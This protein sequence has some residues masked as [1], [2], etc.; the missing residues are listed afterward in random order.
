M[1][2]PPST[3]YVISR[4]HSN[5]PSL[6]LSQKVRK[7]WTDSY[8][9]RQMLMFYPPPFPHPL[10]F[11]CCDHEQ[12][13]VNQVTRC[14]IIYKFDHITPVLQE[15]RWL[16]VRYYLMYTV[17]VLTFKWVK[18]IVSDCISDYF[19]AK[20]WTFCRRENESRRGLTTKHL[21][22]VLFTPLH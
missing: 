1:A 15:L 22:F 8:W 2:W 13:L 21:P 7:G 11:L 17:G 6:N 18:G 5:W 12:Y 20:F 4:N 3:Y 16:P 10:Y 14:Y 19:A 9:E